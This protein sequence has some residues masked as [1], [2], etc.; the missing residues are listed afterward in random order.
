MKLRDSHP[1]LFTHISLAVFSAVVYLI[2]FLVSDEAN[3]LIELSITTAYI[4]TLL[5]TVALSVGPVRVIL[6]ITNPTNIY[7]R[8]DIG[9]WA[10]LS[11]LIH[12]CL[13]TA[14]SMTPEYISTYVD[15]ATVQLTNS[16]RNELFLWGSVTAYA[17]GLLLLL[18]LSLSNDAV[19]RWLGV[20]WWKRLQRLVYL[21]FTLTI[22]HGLMFQ[23]LESRNL[24]LVGLLSALFLLILILQWAGI[25]SV[26][27]TQR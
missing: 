24:I 5:I 25:R 27:K 3:H 8:R 10:A 2:V 7:L 4:C 16:A 26:K 18:L 23:I 21:A 17:T 19:L 13:A 15:V 14:Q 22:V 6:Q 11:G 12:L 9:I 1:R 20:K